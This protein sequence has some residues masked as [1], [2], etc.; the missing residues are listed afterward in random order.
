MNKRFGSTFIFAVLQ[1]SL[2]W[3]LD[4]ST[5]PSQLYAQEYQ[6]MNNALYD[7]RIGDTDKARIEAAF[8]F[9]ACA[10]KLSAE[11]RQQ[12]LK[13]NYIFMRSY[14][15]PGSDYATRMSGLVEASGASGREFVKTVESAFVPNIS[16]NAQFEILIKL[17]KQDSEKIVAGMIRKELA[18]WSADDPHKAKVD[19]ARFQR[20][21]LEFINDPA[22]LLTIS[23]NNNYLAR[24]PLLAAKLMDNIRNLEKI[25][26]TNDQICKIIDASLNAFAI[27]NPAGPMAQFNLDLIQ[28]SKDAIDNYK[29]NNESCGTTMKISDLKKLYNDH[30]AE[31]A[32]DMGLRIGPKSLRPNGTTAISN[33]K[34]PDCTLEEIQ[35]WITFVVKNRYHWPSSFFG[36]ETLKKACYLDLQIQSESKKIIDKNTKKLVTIKLAKIRLQV[37]DPQFSK[38]AEM[39]VAADTVEYSLYSQILDWNIFPD[40][41]N[42]VGAAPAS[43]RGAPTAPVA[44]SRK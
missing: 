7:V 9:T 24:T 17:A 4:C 20:Y 33:Y 41:K 5:N 39:T 11:Q 2:S 18:S 27:F 30:W 16:E 32:V 23:A 26:P 40:K 28:H 6:R 35:K 38:L 44:P 42:S 19:F 8:A 43:Q 36:G 21:G 3:S 25:A 34:N 15:V 1:A 13:D 12:I 29:N 31:K 14:W 37:S 10:N 22:L